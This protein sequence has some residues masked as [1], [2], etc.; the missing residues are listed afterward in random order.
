VGRREGLIGVFFS[1]TEGRCTFRYL[2]NGLGFNPHRSQ[3]N[4]S[5]GME[6]IEALSSQLNATV[7]FSGV[8]GVRYTFTFET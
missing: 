5:I 4:H 1:S 6:L 3:Q 7:G 8:N 2:D